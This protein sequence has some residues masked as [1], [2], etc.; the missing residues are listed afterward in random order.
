MK[1][2]D[3]VVI[4]TRTNAFE[5]LHCGGSYM[6]TLPAPLDLYVSMTKSFV[7]T[8]KNCKKQEKEKQA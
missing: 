8:H 6:P 4:N 1:N 7:K 2:T 5:C 3:H